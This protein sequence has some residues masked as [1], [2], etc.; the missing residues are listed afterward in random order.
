MARD[1]LD[2]NESSLFLNNKILHLGAL[3]II[4]V[5]F[6]KMQITPKPL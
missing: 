5:R 3:L 2:I 1:F 6:L 4:E